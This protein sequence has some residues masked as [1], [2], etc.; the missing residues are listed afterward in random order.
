MLCTKICHQLTTMFQF[1]FSQ[2]WNP[3]TWITL[4]YRTIYYIEK[5]AKDF[6]ESSYSEIVFGA[7]SP[8]CKAKLALPTSLLCHFLPGF[9]SHFRLRP[10]RD[11]LSKSFLSRVHAVVCYFCCNLLCT[12][13]NTTMKLHPCLNTAVSCLDLPYGHIYLVCIPLKVRMHSHFLLR[14]EFCNRFH[15][16]E[17]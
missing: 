1:T 10:P 8:L 7:F 13:S 17:Y 11:S 16:K 6:L 4:T 2:Y 9:F 15:K 5:K 3:I 14:W 12:F